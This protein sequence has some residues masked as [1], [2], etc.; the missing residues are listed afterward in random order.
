M[1]VEVDPGDYHVLHPRPVYLVV[2]RSRGGRL[3]VMSASW[4]SPISDEPFLIAVS[5]WRG[6]LT[7]EYVSE[8]GEFTVNVLGEEHLETAF[9]AGSVSGREVDKWGLLGLKPYPSRHV[10][11]PGVEGALGILECVVENR[12][13]VGE[14]TLFIA[15]VKAVRVNRDL[16]GRYGWNLGKA[17]I[18]MHAGGRAFT[19]SGRLLLAGRS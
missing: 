6:S 10:S 13:P 14:S 17:R 12:V 3:N 5:I 19:V 9:K 7:H 18:L 11:V 4:V 8:T 16:Y 1:Y 2:S 15:G